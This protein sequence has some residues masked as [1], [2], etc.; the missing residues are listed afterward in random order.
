M[1]VF[2]RVE[3]IAS[4]EAGAVDKFSIP[5]NINSDGVFYARV[6]NRLRVSFDEECVSR[7]RGGGREGFF[8]TSAPT[9]SEVVNEIRKAHRIFLRPTVEEKPVI[10]YNIESH[11]SFALDERGVIFPNARFPGAKWANVE[12]SYGGH[13][14]SNPSTGG[15][16]LTIGAR[17]MLKRTSIYG[18]KVSSRYDYYYKGESHLGTENPAQLLNS[19]CS[20][21]LPDDAC[22]IPYSDEAAMFFFNLLKGMAELNRK[23]QEFTNTPEKLIRV[24]SKT[25]WNLLAWDSRNKERP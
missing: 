20:M 8:R 4:N 11:V 9:F 10:R 2:R 6:P 12:K 3:F 24:I 19:W 5:I 15:Y 25:Q 18:D 13:H 21:S 7:E 17:A 23:V 22:E 1:P 16:S 14:C